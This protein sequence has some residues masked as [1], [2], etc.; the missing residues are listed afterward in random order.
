[1]AGLMTSSSPC[2]Q[3]VCWLLTDC[4][5]TAIKHLLFNLT[6][7][8][9]VLM[10]IPGCCEFRGELWDIRTANCAVHRLFLAVLSNIR[11]LGGGGGDTKGQKVI[12]QTCRK[13]VHRESVLRESVLTDWQGKCF[14][15]LRNAVLMR[16]DEGR[17]LNESFWIMWNVWPLDVSSFLL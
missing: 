6:V 4:D 5:Q 11:T 14:G 12:S 7:P 9:K 13:L 16:N 1:M 2:P 3:P 8:S 17:V 10:A 15:P